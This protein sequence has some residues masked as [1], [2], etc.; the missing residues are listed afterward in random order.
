VKDIMRYPVT[1]R[2][3]FNPIPRGYS[4]F[5]VWEALAREHDMHRVP[6]I[7]PDTR[8]M[9]NLVTQSQVIKW[10][11]DNMS[12]LGSVL[13]KPLSSFKTP[14]IK[15]V[16]KINEDEKTIVAFRKMLD[17]HISGVAVVNSADHLTGALSMRDLKLISYDARLFWRL[18]Q[19]AKNYLIKLRREYQERHNRPQRV[20]YA[21]PDDTLKKVVEELAETGVHRVFIVNNA[22][23]KKPIGVVSLQDVMLEVL[24]CL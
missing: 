21:V 23:D 11:H 15:Q 9:W 16:V 20:V 12:K 22:H 8:L 4:A 7:D 6:I 5:A 18:H 1:F 24:E 17:D 3:R 14:I 2:N 19:T 13:H 10:L